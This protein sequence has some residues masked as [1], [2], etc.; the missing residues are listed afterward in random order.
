[1][2]GARPLRPLP[3]FPKGVWN[4]P[5]NRVRLF[6]LVIA[7]GGVCCRNREPAVQRTRVLDVGNCDPDHAAIRN[8]VEAHF[9]AEVDRAETAPE[10]LSALRQSEYAL[11]LVNRILDGDGFE[12]VEWIQQARTLP[13]A[14]DTP[15]MLISDFPEAQERARQ[16]RRAERIRQART[17][18][19][20]D[21]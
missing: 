21:A 5:A 15:I 3:G 6:Q 20:R 2:R 12:G 11:V 1:M 14:V 9:D 4:P 8:L 13:R 16:G 17:E 18:T 19:S 10:A 7:E